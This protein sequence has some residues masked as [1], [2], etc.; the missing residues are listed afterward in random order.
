MDPDSPPPVFRSSKRRRLA[1]Q[2]ITDDPLPNAQAAPEPSVVPPSRRRMFR[3]RNMG[4]D[5]SAPS[6]M[7][8]LQPPRAPMA[9]PTSLAPINFAPPTGVVK[10]DLEKHM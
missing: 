1:R 10:D 8:A 6:A 4:L 2:P 3:A 9:D 7:P 5:V